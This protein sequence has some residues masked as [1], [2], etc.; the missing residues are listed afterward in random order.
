MQPVS[1]LRLRALIVAAGRLAAFTI[2][3]LVLVLAVLSLVSPAAATESGPGENLA[4]RDH[5]Y[6]PYILLGYSLPADRV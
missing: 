6:T 1:G 3:T 2:L 5:R 4:P